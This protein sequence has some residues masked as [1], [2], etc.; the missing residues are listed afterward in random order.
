MTGDLQEN[1]WIL[2]GNNDLLLKYPHT[3]FNTTINSAQRKSMCSH[4]P[5]KLLTVRDRIT[6]AHIP[7]QL[8]KFLKV[9]GNIFFRLKKINTSSALGCV[10]RRKRSWGRRKER[11]FF[12]TVGCILGRWRGV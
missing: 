11:F 3:F 8:H 1:T 12:V 2:R 10:K 7:P 4:A 6:Q 5:S 9:K